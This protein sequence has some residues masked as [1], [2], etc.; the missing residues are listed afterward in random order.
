MIAPPTAEH[1][2]SFLLHIR[3]RAADDAAPPSPDVTGSTADGAT[4]TAA[5]A[6]GTGMDVD[7]DATPPAVADDAHTSAHSPAD[8]G[9]AVAARSAREAAIPPPKKRRSSCGPAHTKH[10]AKLYILC[11]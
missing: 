9:G 11:L 8:D 1:I 2:S 7:T 10:V 5:S 3:R 4:A 6:A